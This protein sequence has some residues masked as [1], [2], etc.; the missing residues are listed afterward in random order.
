MPAEQADPAAPAKKAE[1]ADA[2]HSALEASVE[3]TEQEKAE[4]RRA[5]LADRTV[6]NPNFDESVEVDIST[7]SVAITSGFSGQRIVVFGA[8][9]NSLQASPQQGLYDVVVVLEGAKSKLISR[10]KSNVAGL[11]INTQSVEF[12]SVPSYY[13]ISSTRPIVEISTPRVFDEYGIGFQHIRI[14]PRAA[15]A[16][17]LGPAE[18]QSFR[19]SIIRLKAGE[20][21]YQRRPTGVEFIGRSLFR[22]SIDL[23]A[24]VPIGTVVARTYL[25]RDAELIAENTAAVELQ[26]QGLEALMHSFAFD[27]PL[28]YGMLAVAIAVGAGLAA[29]AVFSRGAH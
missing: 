18:L 3:K 10:R 27:Y 2:Q 22:T 13:T 26:R 7:R 23:P 12:E 29:S 4:R 8:V 24:N 15:D 17:K 14:E 25:F 5:A 20:G 28:L 6:Q 16:A 1:P 9:H 19:E 11:W 21:L